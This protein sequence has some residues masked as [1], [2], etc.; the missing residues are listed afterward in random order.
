MR[1][2]YGRTHLGVVLEYMDVPKASEGR[3]QREL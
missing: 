1:R 2:G 3:L